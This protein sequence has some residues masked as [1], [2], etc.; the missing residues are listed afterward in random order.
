[1][2]CAVDGAAFFCFPQAN[3]LNS[4]RPNFAQRAAFMNAHLRKTRLLLPVTLLLGFALAG[5]AL[6]FGPPGDTVQFSAVDY[7]V[8][9]NVAGGHAQLVVLRTGPAT[10]TVMVTCFTIPATATAG[11]DYTTFSNVLTFPPG[12]TSNTVLVPI[13][14]DALAE[15]NETFYAFLNNPVDAVLG[16]PNPA[17]V[18][19]VD[20]DTVPPASNTVQFVTTTYGRTEDMGLVFLTVSRTGDTSNPASVQWSVTGGTASSPAD[21]GPTNGVLNFAP[22]Q[23]TADIEITIVDDTLVES[24]ETVVLTLSNPTGATLGAPSTAT[25]TI[26]DNDVA[27][28]PRTIRFV[29]DVF[30]RTED[31]GLVYLTVERTGDTNGPASVNWN[32]TGGT[33]GSP[34]DYGPTNGVLHFAPGQAFTYVE[35]TIF[36]DTL[37]EANETVFLALSNPLGAVLGSPSTA[38]LTIFDND[39]PGSA[40]TLCGVVRQCHT[41]GPPLTNGTLTLTSTNVAS[42]TVM[43]DTNGAYCFTNLPAG[44]YTLTPSGADYTFT[45]S[46]A[47]VTVASNT[48][49]P[50]FVG[51]AMFLTGRVVDGTNGPPL[52]GIPVHLTGAAAR[53]NLTDTNGVYVFTNLAAG[54]YTVTPRATNGFRFVPTNAVLQIASATNCGNTASFTNVAPRLVL[55]ALEVIQAVQDWE[56]TVPLVQDKPTLVRAHLELLDT[57]RTPVEVGGAR[58]FGTRPDNAALPGGSVTA[59]NDPVTVRTNDADSVRSN[60]NATLNFDLPASWLNGTVDLRFE[61]TNGVV[62]CREPAEPGGAA[63]NCLVRVAFQ[64]MPALPVKWVRV[65]WTNA[66]PHRPTLANITELER[67]LRAIY[68]IARLSPAVGEFEWSRDDGAP[69]DQNR[70]VE[71]LKIYRLVDILCTRLIGGAADTDRQLY[72]GILVDQVIGGVASPLGGHVS[73][74]TFPGPSFN[75]QRNLHAHEMGHSLGRHHAVTGTIHSEVFTN[76]AGR[77][78]TNYYTEG[79]CGEYSDTNAPAFPMDRLIRSGT[80]YGPYPTLGPMWLGADKIVFGYDSHARLVVHPL[81]TFDLMSYCPPGTGNP[82]PL[83]DWVWISKYTYTNLMNILINRFGAGGAPRPTFAPQDYFVISGQIDLVADTAALLPVT[84]VPAITMPPSPAPGD[85]ALLL[86]DA[87]NN[88]VGLVPFAPDTPAIEALE[89]LTQASFTLAVP[90]DPRVRQIVV[91]HAGMPIGFR[92]ASDGAPTVRV[93]FP[94]GGEVL[95]PGPVTLRWTAGDPEGDALTFLVQYSRDGGDTWETLGAN[96]PH[97]AYEVDQASLKATSQGRIRVIA[98][99]GFNTTRD[100]SDGDFVVGNHAPE[101]AIVEPAPDGLFAGQQ[102]IVFDAS[103][104]DVDDGSLTNIQWTSSLDGL[105]GAGERLH[106]E[107]ATLAEGTH[108]IRAAAKDSAGLTGE[109]TVTIVVSR[110]PPPPLQIALNDDSVAISWPIAGTNYQLQCT[111]TLSPLNW[112]R[113]TNA[114][115]LTEEAVTVTLPRA[116]TTRFYRLIKP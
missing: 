113:V 26:F 104:Y 33:A 101:V 11:A 62:T 77:R 18:T 99:D 91:L 85:Y 47:T 100:A 102:Q 90:F 59:R 51:V 32:V 43:T 54:T 10:G 38:T 94:N 9:E 2:F 81:F 68:P 60:L 7:A 37:V 67:R 31:M 107:A 116:G 6:A 57:N 98:S 16:V 5:S 86:L 34:A 1:V 21:Y 46:N 22:N 61:W 115:A 82:A 97:T 84:V 28:P 76:D 92:A 63:S 56:N 83:T 35:I 89:E 110:I 105:L 75:Y 71:L 3:S 13:T 111:E 66:T 74:G 50:T 36:E 55:R 80:D 73:C 52:P 95:P 87:D 39:T 41:N 15:S 23:S 25:L 14:D 30:G 108:L 72:Y 42:R 65:R 114:P 106:R 103:A 48:T 69:R 112:Q 45:P 79:V 96:W 12:L 64:P 49:A 4:R 70:L 40:R 93:D 8:A 24:N 109:A 88:M 17:T 27:P 20:N 19:I 29:T 44:T 53:T 58:L 78:M